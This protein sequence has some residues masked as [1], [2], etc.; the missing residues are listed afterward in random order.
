M[1]RS[2]CASPLPPPASTVKYTRLPWVF[3][4]IASHSYPA[5][6]IEH[7]CGQLMA[8]P[9]TWRCV[10]RRVF[11]PLHHTAAACVSRAGSCLVCLLCFCRK[12]FWGCQE[13][14][15]EKKNPVPQ[16]LV[17]SSCQWFSS[18]VISLSDLRFFMPFPKLHVKTCFLR[19]FWGI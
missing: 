2:P 10:L 7:E 16:T 11:S 15:K 14:I 17:I 13:E 9:R 6:G 18:L 5:P 8:T 12:T 3:C 4:L 1:H 19:I